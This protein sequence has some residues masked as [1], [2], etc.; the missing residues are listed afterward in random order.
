MSLIMVL[1]SFLVMMFLSGV[2]IVKGLI[3]SGL[4]SLLPMY[5]ENGFKDFLKQSILSGS[6]NIDIL[7]FLTV[8]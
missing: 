8:F 5:R 6:T 2:E 3:V 1:T 4:F 7:G